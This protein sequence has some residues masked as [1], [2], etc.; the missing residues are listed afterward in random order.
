MVDIP[1][2]LHIQ[3]ENIGDESG[4]QVKPRMP[5]AE[6]IQCGNE[7]LRM[8]ILENIGQMGLVVNLLGL[9]DFEH[10][11]LHRQTEGLR[12]L[13]SAANTVLGLVN[14]IG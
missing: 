1:H 4:Q 14:R 6:I 3:L 10:D 13:K 9:G 7:S 5:G 2:Q 8:V 12:R 11:L